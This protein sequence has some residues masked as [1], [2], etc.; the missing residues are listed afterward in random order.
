M[1]LHDVHK[2]IQKNKKRRRVGRGKG[3]GWGK[4]SGRGHKGQGQVAGW[5]TH[6]AFAGGQ[7]P[8]FRR[9]PKRGFNNR[10]AREIA[11]INLAQLD[12]LFQAGEEVTPQTVQSKGQLKKPFELLKV[13]GNGELTKG[14]K[15]SAHRF[16]KSALEKIQQAG[17]EAVILPS[18]APVVKWETKDPAKRARKPRKAAPPAK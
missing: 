14:L 16:S 17:G 4:T 15:V 1:N 6:A 13:L 2:G 10:W 7:S 3:S 18:A 12:G 8:L 11:V 5:T 9:V